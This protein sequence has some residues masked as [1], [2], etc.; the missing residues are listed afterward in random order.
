MMNHPPFGVDV[1]EM[2]FFFLSEAAAADRFP[3]PHHFV[4]SCGKSHQ[5]SASSSK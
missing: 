4:C 1:R 5:F 2:R 3:P